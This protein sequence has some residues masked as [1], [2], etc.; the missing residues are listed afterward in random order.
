VSIL[1]AI[2]AL[3]VDHPEIEA[4]DLNPVIVVGTEAIAADALV[5]IAG[6]AD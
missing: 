1:L 3:A 4:V 6:K 2:S 5:V